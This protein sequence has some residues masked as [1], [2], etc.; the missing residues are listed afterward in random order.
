MEEKKEFL[1]ENNY[2][3]ANQGLFFAGVGLIIFGIVLFMVIFIPKVTSGT[4]ANKTQ[5]QQQLNQ[6]QPALENRYAQLKANGVM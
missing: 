6:L 4:K 5:L 3:K 1:N 2:Q